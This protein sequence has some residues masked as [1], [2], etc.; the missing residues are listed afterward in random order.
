MLPPKQR[1]KALSVA[2]GSPKLLAS[3]PVI[4]VKILARRA[5]RRG[6]CSREACSGLGCR[7]EA[8]QEIRS[9]VAQ[10]R[11]QGQ[12]VCLQHLLPGNT[13]KPAPPPKKKKLPW[14]ASTNT[15]SPAGHT[16]LKRTEHCSM[17]P[18]LSQWTP[19]P[20]SNHA[21]TE[22]LTS[23]CSPTRGKA[24]VNQIITRQWHHRDANAA[25]KGLV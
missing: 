14:Q 3:Q 12:S 6:R 25:G 23:P 1:S 24:H 5:G 20:P 17:S 11:G 15:P 8:G 18:S 9:L 4:Y 22:H 16:R 2:R 19:H 21:T 7:N 10:T 13:Q